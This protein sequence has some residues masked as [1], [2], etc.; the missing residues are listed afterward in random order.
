MNGFGDI[1]DFLTALQPRIFHMNGS[2]CGKQAI[3]EE[4]VQWVV[5]H[6]DKYQKEIEGQLNGF[7]LL[8]GGRSVQLLHTARSLAKKVVRIL[9][10]VDAAGIAVPDELH[11]MGNVLC[12]LFFRLTVVINR[13]LGVVEPPYE[14][15]SYNL[16]PPKKG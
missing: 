15:L 13:R 12:N 7:V 2:I 3:F 8:H 1:Y 5:E 4:Q 6:F 10:K 11:R 14:S 16:K 9:V